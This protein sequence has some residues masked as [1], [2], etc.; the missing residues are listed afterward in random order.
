MSVKK[1]IDRGGGFLTVLDIDG[2]LLPKLPLEN[3]VENFRSLRHWKARKD[4]VIVC[5]YPK[6]EL[7]HLEF[8]PQVHFDSI[9]SPRI[10][11]SH[12]LFHQL[13]EDLIK[14]KC[15]I[16]FIDRD[17]KDVAVSFYHHH[18]KLKNYEYEGKWENYLY[19][20][21]E[22]KVDFGSWF[23]YT[24][25]WSKVIKERKDIPFYVIHYEEM[26]K[27]NMLETSKLANFL[28]I[29]K[30]VNLFQSINE[31]CKF[32]AM[33]KDK[34]EIEATFLWKEDDPGMY[35]KAHDNTTDATPH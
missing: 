26:L 10:L 9:P 23:D 5:V 16:V 6:S 21:L 25:Q 14:Q 24:L 32:D 30:D 2:V 13:P 11:N 3:Q 31:L 8:L 33:K 28:G 18:K 34:D 27:N 12:L 19:M 15:K 17:P 29:K 35:R 7:F 4:D 1:I 22:G 20:F